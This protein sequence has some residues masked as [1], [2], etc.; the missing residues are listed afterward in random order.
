MM[1]MGKTLR[2][3]RAW[4]VPVTDNEEKEIR[5]AP[6]RPRRFM[7]FLFRLVLLIVLPGA[8]ALI[9]A[10]VYVTGQRY[11][12]SENAFVKANKIAVS[13]EVAGKVLSVDVGEHDT[14]HE[15]QILFQIDDEA[16]RIEQAEA[17]AALQRIRNDVESLRA[18]YRVKQA[19]LRLARYDYSY[20][21]KA[22]KRRE[23][24]RAR[25]NTSEESFDQARRQRNS[26]KQNITI[27]QQEIRQILA[28]LNGDANLKVEDYPAF[29]QAQAVYDRASLNLQRTVVRAPASG[30]ISKITMEPGEFV[31]SEEPLFAVISDK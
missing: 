27:L 17:H 22:Y 11:V 21:D 30:R 26:A 16:Y 31:K 12:T 7:K 18:T 5:K 2:V 23:Q 6:R 15:G 9:G 3:S 8:A 19:E 20:F 24:L 4:E 29:L 14:V 28:G 10:Y 1:L 25:C 13:S